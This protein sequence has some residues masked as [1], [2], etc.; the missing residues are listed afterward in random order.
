MAKGKNKNLWKKIA[1]AVAGV[2]IIG[3]FVTLAVKLDRQTSTTRIGSEKYSIGTID[4]TGKSTDTNTSIALTKA[5]TV[6][7]LKCEL[8]EGAKI[9][10][11]IFFYDKD[12]KFISST[13]ELSA[14]FDGEGIPETAKT[15]RIMITPTA[16][17]DGS[18]SIFEKSGYKALSDT[19]LIYY[20]TQVVDEIPDGYRVK[21]ITSSHSDLR[22][23]PNAK[24]PDDYTKT[25]LQVLIDTNTRTVLPISVEYTDKWYVV[26]EYLQEYAD[27]RIRTGQSTTPCFAQA[28]TYEGEV[29]VADYADIYALTAENVR[30]ILGADKIDIMGLAT[31]DTVTVTYD[32]ISTYTVQ[33]SYTYAMLKATNYDGE[34]KE[35]KI[36][37]SSYA[38]WCDGLGQEWSILWLNTSGRRYF[39][40]SN[41]V[42]REDLYGFFSVAVFDHHVSDLNYWFRETEGSGFVS[43]YESTEVKGS[44][45]YKNLSR[46][47]DKLIVAPG[48]TIAMGVSELINDDNKMVHSHFFYLDGTTNMSYLGEN[49]PDDYDDTDGA[50]G[51]QIQDGIDNVKDWWNDITNSPFF[52][53]VKT[54]VAVFAILILIILGISIGRRIYDW[55]NSGTKNKKK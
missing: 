54:V 49:D 24:S 46:I 9:T 28:M 7:G 37:L 38:D 43:V 26:V 8:E 4:A 47:R 16:D 35:I 13:G 11:Q 18:V 50:L 1:I 25:K 31:V 19:S 39:Q 23:T 21:S 52:Q 15:A 3:A 32:K 36:P 14:D 17:E 45:L 55:A 51:N 2:L 12:G 20:G 30:V 41:D 6:D 44:W 40:Y 48:A 27:L 22:I 29:R 33:L 42:A 5:I 53:A 10:Y 34:S